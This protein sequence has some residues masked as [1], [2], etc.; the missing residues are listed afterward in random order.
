MFY[1]LL[2]IVKLNL[3]GIVYFI[4]SN[5]HLEYFSCAGSRD[6][7]LHD[8]SGNEC[9]LLRIQ[10]VIFNFERS[11]N[12]QFLN[13]ILWYI[14]LTMLLINRVTRKFF[15]NN[16]LSTYIISLIVAVPLAIL[17]KNLGAV[18]VIFWFTITLSIPLFIIL[19]SLIVPV[20]LDRFKLENKVFQ[21]ISLVLSPILFWTLISVYCSHRSCFP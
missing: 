15:L 13:I 8:L 11:L 6:G 21:N 10:S 12:G 3:G 14:L 20:I 18:T 9:N 16:I 2:F 4:Y 1:S 17:Y 7:G 19:Y 5:S